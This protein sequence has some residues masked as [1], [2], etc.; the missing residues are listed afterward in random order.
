MLDKR[1]DK[2]Q[3]TQLQQMWAAQDLYRF[4]ASSKKPIFSIDT[5]PPTVSGKLHIG[6]IFSYT[7]AEMVARYKRMRGFEVFYP[8]GFDD[9]GLP[10]E[11]LVERDLGCRAEEMSRADFVV[12]CMDISGQYEKEFRAL[13][14]SLG[15]SVDWSL[16]Y[17]TISQST[18]RIAQ[19]E[20]LQLL[21]TD[22]AY[23]AD[24]PVLWCPHCRT[25]IAQAEAETKEEDSSFHTLLFPLVDT[26]T[27]GESTYLPVATTRPELLYGCVALFIHPENEK[28]SFAIGRHATVPLFGHSIPILAN[29]DADPDKGTGIVMC[30]TFGDAADAD[31]F[32]TYGLPYRAVLGKDGRLGNEVP[33]FA[34]LSIKAARQKTV[35]LLTTSGLL[36]QSVPVSHLLA[37]HE[38]CGTPL[39]LLPSRQWYI[40]ILDDKQRWLDAADDINWYPA[41]MKDRYLTWV[42]GLKWDWCVSRQRHFGVPIPVWFC[43]DCGTKLLPEDADL[44][45]D[46]QMTA[47]KHAC[48][49]CGSRQFV[50][51][52]S[53]LDTWATSSLTP[54]INENTLK[55]GPRSEE[56]TDDANTCNEIA[57]NDLVTR[58]LQQTSEQDSLPSNFLPMSMRTQAHEIIRTWTFYTIVRSL[59][60]TGHIPWKDIMLCGFVLAGKG[61]KIS[62]SKNNAVQSPQALIESRSADCVR[63][64]AATARLGTDTV[65]LPQELDVSDR[66]LNKLWNAARF[67]EIHLQGFQPMKKMHATPTINTSSDAGFSFS[68]T[69]GMN[70]HEPA[71]A[72]APNAPGTDRWILAR[73]MDAARK[74]AES[75][76]VYETAE[77]RKQIDTLFWHDFCDNYL[78]LAKDRLYKPE[79]YGEAATNSAKQTLY[80]ALHMLLTLYAPFV[81][82]ITEAIYLGVLAPLNGADIPSIHRMPWPIAASQ[83]ADL[84]AFGGLL[85]DILT[86]ARRYKTENGLSMKDKLP[87]LIISAPAALE[88]LLCSSLPDIKSAAGADEPVI[89]WV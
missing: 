43:T 83:P 35:E 7:Q 60:S 46:P 52:T 80:E 70:A 47:P 26:G 22:K 72:A 15:F 34:G 76:D 27:D 23:T 36:T 33:Q 78:E 29:P 30:A 3:E 16:A 44:P 77:A 17:R 82:H 64:W 61:E 20:F 56:C 19:T 74:A 57:A 89:H 38:R 86:R 79:V 10:T 49:A 9:N 88:S 40:R 48:P 5:P 39:E 66:F 14:E 45:L 58:I 73:I 8:F 65:F 32:K 87:E 85:D 1:F 37:T 68:A 51:E 42:S 62:K 28:W 75:L 4:D 31:W 71:E 12:Q 55:R 59:Y 53:V 6:H 2:H 24:M 69:N 50:P 63:Y 41:Y 25:S 84:L 18:W 21:R 11:R 81:P 13:W 67:C 54:Q